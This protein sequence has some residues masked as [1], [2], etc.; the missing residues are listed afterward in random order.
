MICYNIL[1][2]N[3]KVA[4]A[5]VLECYDLSISCYSM[6]K[7]KAPISMYDLFPQFVK[8][9]KMIKMNTQI[10][11]PIMASYLLWSGIITKKKSFMYQKI[12]LLGRYYMSHMDG[13][14]W[15]D[16]CW[17]KHDLLGKY[18]WS[19]LSSLGI[20]N[21]F[22]L[23]SKNLILNLASLKSIFWHTCAW[24]DCKT[25]IVSTKLL[26]LSVLGATTLVYII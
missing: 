2:Y 15:L 26:T 23:C 24:L 14:K 16:S 8:T 1:H 17:F 11:I 13:C 7:V 3:Q 6:R 21:I 9:P 20:H 19:T 22:F 5:L 12:M 10:S 18:R 25:Y 4:P